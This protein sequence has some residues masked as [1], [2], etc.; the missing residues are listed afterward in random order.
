MKDRYLLNKISEM[1]GSWRSI[2]NNRRF[3]ESIDRNDDRIIPE[4]EG[5]DL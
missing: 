5:E 2:N 1:T 3:L 4:A